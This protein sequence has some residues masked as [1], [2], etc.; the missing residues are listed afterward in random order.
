MSV[1]KVDTSVIAEELRVGIRTDV[2]LIPGVVPKLVGF[3][4]NDDP[5]TTQRRLPLYR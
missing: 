5:A 1:K 4:A 3:L 2:G